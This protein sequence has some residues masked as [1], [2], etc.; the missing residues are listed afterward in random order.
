LLSWAAPE[1]RQGDPVPLPLL[2]R[3]FP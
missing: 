2:L 1:I 3:L